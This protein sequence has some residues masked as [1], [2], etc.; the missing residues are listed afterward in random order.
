ME[1]K[2]NAKPKILWKMSSTSEPLSITGIEASPLKKFTIPK[3]KRAPGKVYLSPCCTNTREYSFIHDTLNQCRLN[4]SF[5]LQSSWQFG[6]TKLVHNEDLEK[7]FTAK[8]S[9]MRESGRHGRELEEHFCFLALPQSD[10]AEIYQNGIST[11][12]STLK[13]LGNPFLGIYIFRHVDVALN[14]AHSRNIT[15]ESIIIFKVLFG[16]VKKIQPSVDKN[17]V[18]LDPSPN[19]DCHMSRSIP[20]LKDNVELQAYS[21]AVYFYEY[22][23]LLRPVDKPRQCLPYAIVTV[24]FI[25]QKV[26][27]GHLMTSLRFL[28]TGF[29]KRAERTCSLNNCTVAKRIGKG[30]DATVIF[31]HFRK[32]IDPFV[33]ENCSCNALNSEINPSNNMSNSYGNVQNGNISVHEAHS[34]QTEHNLAESSD[35]SKVHAHDSDLSLMPIDNREG[36]NDDLLLNLTYLK[37]VLSGISTAFPLHNNIGSSTVITSKLIKD[38]R[39]IRREESIGK[40]NNMAGL[41]EIL[42]LEKSLNYVNSELNLSS[43][44]TNSVSSPEVIPGDHTVLTN[45]LDSPCFK[46][47]LDNLPPSQAH[48]T[49]SKDCDYTTLNKITMAGQCI[50]QG[51]STSPISLSNAVSELENQKGSEEKSQRSQQRSNM[52]LLLKENSEPHKYYESVNTCSEG[53]N[54]PI[55]Q[56]SQSSNLKTIYQSS[57]QISTVSPLQK[58]ESIHKCF[59]NIGKMRNLKADPEDNYE[60]GRKQ[61]LWKGIENCF[62]NEAKNSPLDKYISF[63]KESENLDS[64]EKNCDQILI[65]QELEIPKSF[66]LV[67]K[68]KHEADNVAMELQNHLTPS[69]ESLSLK[70]L[71]HSLKY[72]NSINTSFAISQKLMEPKMEKTNPSGISI[73][74]D[75]F[76]E[77]K[78][79]PQA[80]ELRI[81]TVISSHD[82]EIA[83]DNS[84]CSITREYICVCRKKENDSTSLENIQI[85]FKE[86]VHIEDKGQSHPLSC[87]TQLNNDIY[88]KLI[89]E[90]EDDKDDKNEAKENDIVLSTENNTE[91]IYGDGKQDFH[92][93]KNIT[94]RDERKENKN[95]SDVEFSSTINLTWGEKYV[96]TEAAL[97]ESED[98]VIAIKQKDTLNNG[99][100][101]EHL[102]STKLSEVTDSSA[103][104]AS[105][106]AVQIASPALPPVS[107]NHEDHQRY[108]FKE[109][110]SPQSPDFGLLVKHR[111]SDCEIGLNEDKNLQDSFHQSVIHENTGIL[112]LELENEI[113]VG[114]EQCDDSSQFQPDIYNHENVLYEELGASY[115]A[116]KSRID[117]KALLGGSNW[118]TEVLK[119]TMRREDRDH[120][121]S[122]ESSC[123][124]SSAQKNKAGLLNPILLPD[125]QVRIT[126]IFRPGFNPPAHSLALKDDFCKCVTES[127]EPE[128]N[129]EK[130]PEFEIHSQSPH[131]NSDYPCEEEY[132]NTRKDSGLVSK[133]EISLS[134]DLSHNSH[135][136]HMSEKQNSESLCTEPS[137]IT[138][139]NNKC[140][141]TESKTDCNDTRSKKH[142]ESRI[143]KRKQHVSFRDQRIS[144]KDLRHHEIY[145]KK[146]RLTSQDSF[147]CFTS[148][149]QGRIKTFSQSEK[150][151][152][153]VLDILNS[154]ASLCKSK[155]LS[156]KLDRAVLHLKK[157]HRRVH[158]SLQLIAKV[159]ENKKGPLPKSYAIICNNFWESCDLEG[160]SSV[161]ERKYYSAKQFL[162]KRKYDKQGEKRTL[163]SDVGKS[164][165]CVSK[166]KSYKRNEDKKNMANSVSRSQTTIHL[167]EFCEQEKH[168]ESSLSSMSQSPC[169]SV[170]SNSMGNPRS[171]DLQLLTGKTEFLFPPNCPDEKLPEKE[172]KIVMN[173]L[174]STGKYEK[175]ENHSAH[176]I[177]DETEEINSKANGVVSKSNSLSLSCIEENNVSFSLDK[178]YD[179][180]CVTHTEVKTDILISVV[181]SSLKHFLNVDV[182]KPGNLIL[183]E[184]KRN[185]QMNF[186]VEKWA[187]P[188]ENSKPS[189]IT[190]N[191]PMD[192]LNQ[193]ASKNYNSI[194]QLLSA[195]PVEASEGESSK[196]YLDKQ[197]VFAVDSFTTSTTVSRYHQ[198]YCGE[199]FLKTEKCC[200]SNYLQI[201]CNE[202]NIAENS[203]LDLT[204]LTEE[205][206]SSGENMKKLNSNDSSLLVTG[207]IKCSSSKYIA[208]K[209]IQNRKMCKVKQAEKANDSVRGVYHKKS[210]SAVKAEY[211]N[212]KNKILEKEYPNLNEKTLKNN[213]IDSHLSI[214]NTTSTEAIALN[215]TVPNHLN[216]REKEGKVKDSQS[217]L[218]LLSETTCN[219]KPDII[220]TNHMPISHTHSETSEVTTSQNKLTAC[221]NEFKEKHCSANHTAVM[222]KLSQI[223]QRA[224]KASSFQILQEET[225]VCQNIL[226][227]FVEAFERKQ[228]CALEQI[229]ISRELLV[230]QNLWNNC[231]H[232]LKPCA[233][234]SL[235]ELQMMMETIQFIE[236]KKRLLGGEPTFRSLLWYDETLYSELL[237]GPRGYQQQSNFYPA[238]QGRLKYNAFCELQNYHDQLIELFQETKRE[239]NS[240]YAFL[241]Y[242]RQ[243]IECE[244][245]MKHC[246]D[247]F[248]FSLS[249]PFTCGVNFG[250][251]LGDLETLRKSTLELISIY[252]D[253][254]KVR[255]YPGKQDHLWIIIEMISS[256]VNF[257][258]SSEAVNIKISL[259]GLEH[260]FFDAAKSLVWKEK[261]QSLS[262]KYSQKKNKDVLLKMNQDAFSKLQKIYDTLFKDLGSEQISSIGLEEDTMIPFRKSDDLKNNTTSIENYKFN[263]TL[264]SHPDICC[265]SEILDQAE[266]ADFKKL[267]KLTLRCTDHLEILKKY[268]QMLQEDSID[269]IFI[270]EE[271]VLDMVKNNNCGS[272]ILKPEAIETYIEI[273]MLSETV[274]FLKNSMAKKLD[275]QRFRGML[276]F[277]LSL[278]PELVDCQEEMASFSFLKDNSTDCLWK[279]IETAISALKKDLDIT[280]KYNEAINC[281]YALHLFSRELEELSEIKKL[282]KKSDCSISTYIDFVPYIASI[283]YGSTV[284]ELEYNYNQ[285]STLLK[286]IM[287]APR[288]DLGKVAHIMKVMK[289]I[290]HMKIICTKNAKLTIS[291]IFYQMLYNRKRTFHPKIKE[292]INIHVIKP[293]KSISKSTCIKVPLIPECIIKN[294]SNSSKK[295]P[296]TVHVCEDSQEQEKN[297]T[298]SSCKKQKVNME[299][300]TNVNKEKALF[301]NPRT[302]KS[303][304][305]SENE[306]RPSS[307]DILKRNLVPP[308]KTQMQKSHPDSLLPL[309]NLK[310]ICMSKSESKIDLTTISSDTSEDF[311]GQQGNL[312]S[313]KK[314]KVNFGAAE[315]KSDKDFAS[316]AIC[317]KKG[318]I[319]SEDHETPS[320]KFLKNP[321]DPAQNSCPS[322]IKPGIN[323]SF[324]PNTS[325]LSKPILHFVR[326]IHTN[327]GM[328]EVLE[329]Q[330]NEMLNS[331]GKNSTCTNSPELLS[332]Q[333]KIPVLQRNKTQP[334]NTESEERYTK[335]TL[336]SST[337]PVGASG[338]TTLNVNQTT[339]YS[340]SDQ[341]SNENSKALTENTLAHWNEF[342]QSAY[343][344]VYNS[345]EQ[346]FGTSYPYYAWCVY[347]YSS[348]NG[349]SIT[350]TYHGITSCDTPPPPPGMLTAVGSTVQSMYSNLFYSQHFGYFAGEPQAN[351][352]VPV[353]GYFQ[354]QIPI[355]NFQQAI[356]P[357]YIS[358]QPLP[359]AACPYPPNTAVLSEVPW[360]YATWQ[361]EPFQPGH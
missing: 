13:I 322:N 303:H 155:R 265:I 84:N 49:C 305:Q 215:N 77:A 71:H 110:C 3:I 14:Y 284:T 159:G 162:S 330:N 266:H 82:I 209:D 156:R 189:I 66:K 252:G 200:S 96:S 158:T 351:N 146:R 88:L 69:I 30:K 40:Q 151:I 72:G 224:D 149:S 249:I 31:E 192:P 160:Y 207:N 161:S 216:K 223:L 41:N 85:D 196:S 361:Q 348:S 302:T 163:E 36:I 271:N 34:G 325:V 43:M 187:A 39:L 283:N 95:C 68:N 183:S 204:S 212:Q 33:Q 214:K 239:N 78:D 101:L 57:H 23:V 16:K 164:L 111:V 312:N 279:V 318:D 141:F 225:K 119:S 276:W 74:T 226:P 332:I 165:T 120:L 58:K 1:M 234:D 329:L 179:A 2:E 9:E 59:E 106:A 52:P 274:H 282:L 171:S 254:H 208:E 299:D 217:D 154:E 190:G 304:P 123:L 81:G 116:L 185:L 242:K 356:C 317:D 51:N 349:N 93:N 64:S 99:R 70:P 258:K 44:P 288:K 344:P 340:F 307:S 339:E 310:D 289:T 336:N 186:P 143:S 126:N 122:E 140:S 62:T 145:G 316:F 47:S 357:Q 91:N 323:T 321:P 11:K 113:E 182:Y 253:S 270:T 358:H 172:N 273:V 86:T 243:I 65:T 75:A 118:E 109:T 205:S 167:K 152:R 166:H 22:N 193:I 38:P 320:Q 133:S 188:M 333:N 241:K 90:Q 277:D 94:S 89:K 7:N 87:D 105:D 55:A 63:H 262:K 50:G 197:E 263:S 306:I 139:V 229:L 184:C 60:H 228:E 298:P 334:E 181:E 92:A 6:D 326:D 359:Q 199:E 67:T 19:F 245:I 290:E 137:A 202:T 153:S 174:S 132:D 294:V 129:E 350:Q 259:Y 285:F 328:D 264:L 244:A 15:V 210:E 17:K 157:A 194:P 335:D 222:A 236:N 12:A 168:S 354:S 301:K 246:S 227:V 32:P 180:T 117:W 26:D 198:E 314:R 346:S 296:S 287:A 131:E 347:H 177:K 248:D 278:L 121:Y 46:I 220:G 176:D 201:G 83:H 260:I 195:T 80:N 169:Q 331:P 25:G 353:N 218:T 300:V 103:C 5:D 175:L 134:F 125:L 342:P 230:G 247:C 21:S 18:S 221:M 10:V 255:S 144:H 191:F 24:K 261:R 231:K 112:S 311:P 237:S 56:E 268:F 76:Q 291:Y 355:Y 213:L 27:N 124:Y 108:Q 35:T 352:F 29:P 37:N 256:K 178:N 292:K 61:N 341:Q 128:I 315:T 286:N 147:E 102:A 297:A 53:Y 219:F 104:V 115:E 127:V 269:N 295:R 343:T 173:F 45:Y 337:M 28:S 54:R 238:F 232:K 272:I 235:V 138:A 136:N 211:K 98:T 280:Y 142:L 293:G 150:H 345:S 100:I 114:S 170:Y 324:P 309:K 148:L 267:Q 130:V 8:R 281:S 319:F 250:D 107:T 97:L 327:L 275:K 73:V 313:L 240:Y 203:E 206:K 308:K 257:I 48:N 251:S 4:V 79:I 135:M 338:S 20:S 42:P 233:V 360:T